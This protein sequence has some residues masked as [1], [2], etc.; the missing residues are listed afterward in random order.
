MIWYGSLMSQV[1]QHAIGRV[2]LQPRASGVL[3]DFVNASRAK[4]GA[5]VGVF[6]GAGTDA[7]I[8]V[9]HL[10]VDRLV[11]VVFG[12]GEVHAGQAIARR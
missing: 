1:L 11:F 4:A 8:G 2:D 7:D 10:Q 6:L 3:H 5:R 9:E 12:R